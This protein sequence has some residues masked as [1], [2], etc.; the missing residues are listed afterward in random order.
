M[1]NDNYGS[2]EFT[3]DLEKV[4]AHIQAAFKILDKVEMRDHVDA[5][6]NNFSS[7]IHL[8]KAHEQLMFQLIHLNDDFETFTETI[9]N[10]D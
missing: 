10:L 1:A 8:V 5:T 7:P 4:A 2:L 3:E 9:H 6:H